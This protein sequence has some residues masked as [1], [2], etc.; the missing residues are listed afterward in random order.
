MLSMDMLKRFAV[1]LEDTP[2]TEI[3]RIIVASIRRQTDERIRHSGC[4][5]K[6]EK[7]IFACTVNL[8]TGSIKF[9]RRNVEQVR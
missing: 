7:R 6:S 5:L 4:P 9:R 2:E 8:G 1:P 3:R